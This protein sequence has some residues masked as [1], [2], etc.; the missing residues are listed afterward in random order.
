M[1]PIFMPFGVSLKALAQL[2]IFSFVGAFSFDQL[3]MSGRLPAVSFVSCVES[4]GA[5]GMV[6]IPT[7]EYCHIVS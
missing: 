3:E 6:T 7:C 1:M 4:G 2:A 5:M